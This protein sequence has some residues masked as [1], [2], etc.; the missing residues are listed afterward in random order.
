L[1]RPKTELYGLGAD[2]TRLQL[3]V[4]M[5]RVAGI[6]IAVNA[7]VAIFQW[8]TNH[9]NFGSSRIL[10]GKRG[11]IMASRASDINGF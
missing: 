11:G 4:V 7:V 9:Y 2:M 3:V 6:L 5:V 8:L 10:V 1:L